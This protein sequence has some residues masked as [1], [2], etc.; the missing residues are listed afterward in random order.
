MPEYSSPGGRLLAKMITWPIVAYA[1]L[2]P[3]ALFV[4]TIRWLEEGEG[5][6]LPLLSILW[7]SALVVGAVVV[8]GVAAALL[9]NF[10]L[11]LL[12]GDEARDG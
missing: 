4:T 5:A 12:Q 9:V 11:G 2:L 6:A 10:L 1:A 8:I 7:R 3:G